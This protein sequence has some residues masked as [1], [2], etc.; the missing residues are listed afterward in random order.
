M[1]R[2]DHV[3]NMGVHY[4]GMGISGGEEGALNGPALMPGGSEEAWD[5]VKDIFQRSVHVEMEPTPLAESWRFRTLCQDVHNGIE[6]GDMQLI[7]EAYHLMKDMIGLN[8]EEIH[9]AFL[10]WNKTELRRI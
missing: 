5:L 3:E 7:A 2:T 8:N 9:Q 10:E 4:M 1:R 6:Y